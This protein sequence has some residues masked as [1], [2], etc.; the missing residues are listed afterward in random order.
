ME[1]VSLRGLFGWT[2]SLEGVHTYYG[3]VPDGNHSVLL[4]LLDRGSTEA[5]VVDNVF[6]ARPPMPVAS[7]EF[8]D[9]RG[10][11]QRRE[12]GIRNDT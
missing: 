3:L 1:T 8:Q 4:T 6:I 7:V 2:E 11:V 9:T 10:I 5:L 12:T